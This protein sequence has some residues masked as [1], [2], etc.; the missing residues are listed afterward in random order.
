MWNKLTRFRKDNSAVAAV[1]FALLAPLLVFVMVVEFDVYRY[2]MTTQRLEIVAESVAEMFASATASPSALVPGNGVVA[3]W[4]INFYM[5]SAYFVYPEIL[6]SP[7]VQQGSAWW[8]AMEVDTAGI[9]MIQKTPGVY[10]PTT[11]WHGTNQSG[12]NTRQCNTTYNIVNNS[13]VATPATL[14]AG[15]IGPNAIIAVDVRTTFQPTFG[16]A[17]MPAI[18]IVR[19]VF[20]TPRNVPF[21]EYHG[22]GWMAVNC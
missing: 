18:P 16:A 10:T 9:A 21:V 11:V 7:A 19:S 1:E 12:G 6:T 13:S 4:D 22:T 14:P 8:T 15:V 2:V 3:D 5:N 20:M 17:Y